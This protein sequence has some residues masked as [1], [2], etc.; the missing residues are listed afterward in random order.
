MATTNPSSPALFSDLSLSLKITPKTPFSLH[1]IRLAT[2]RAKI[3]KVVRGPISRIDINRPWPGT[4]L[5]PSP[6]ITEDLTV[7]VYLL[8]QTLYTRPSL[9]NGYLP[10]ENLF[11]ERLEILNRSE[12]FSSRGTQSFRRLRSRSFYTFYTFILIM[13]QSPCSNIYLR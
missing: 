6:Y 2:D 7:S 5:I 8:H 9:S 1:P 4:L 10:Y 3:I 13:S 12:F 11:V